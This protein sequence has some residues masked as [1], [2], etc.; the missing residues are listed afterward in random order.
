LEPREGESY[1]SLALQHGIKVDDVG[2]HL[3]RAKARARAIVKAIV[4]DYTLPDEDIE[5]E[6]RLIL[7]F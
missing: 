1:E 7:T 6:L 4:R 3:R 2:N 5:G